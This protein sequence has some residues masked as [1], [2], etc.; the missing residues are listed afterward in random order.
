MRSSNDERLTNKE[1]ELRAKIA[2]LEEYKAVHEQEEQA[3]RESE[4]RIRF[5][6]DHSKELI[7]ILNKKG[8]IVF[9]NNTALKNYGYSEEEII[10]KSIAH[11]LTKTS[12]KNAFFALAQEFLRRPQRGFEV[13]IKAK[14]GEIR[15]LNIAEGSVPIY[16]NGKLTSVMIRAIDITEQK[17]AES[18]LRKSEMRFRELWENAP[19][20]YHALDLRGTITEA[21][22][23]EAVMLGYSKEELVGKSIFDFILPEQRADARRRFS[24]KISGRTLPRA[25]NRVYVKKDGSR[26][27]VAIDDILERDLEGNITG[28]RTAMVDI[29]KQKEAEEALRRSE[30]LYRDLVEN[31]GI[32]ILIDDREGNFKYFNNKFAKILGYSPDELKKLSVWSTIHPDDVERVTT[33]NRTRLQGRGAPSRYEFKG[34]R[35]DGSPI[36]LEKDVVV[37]KEGDS[38]IGTRSYIWDISDRK[39]ADEALQRLKTKLELVDQIQGRIPRNTDLETV[40]L[41]TAESIGESFGYYKISVNLYDSKTNEIVYLTGWNKTGLPLPRGHRQKLG[42]GLIG[43]AGLLRQTIVANDVSKEPGY[44]SLL[45]ATK[46]ELIIPLLIE[47]QLL[48][49]LDLQATEVN[50]FSKDDVSVLKAVANYVAYVIAEKQRAEALA[51]ERNL[52]RTLID[53]LPDYIYVKDAESRFMIANMA[54]ARSFGEKT[55]EEIVGKTDRD[56]HSP[57]LAERFRADEQAVLT[58]GQAIINREEFVIDSSGNKKWILSTKLPMRDR[59]GNIVGL[60]GVGRDITERKLAEEAI[61]DSEEKF[62]RLAEQSPNIVFIYV[63]DR[64]VYANARAA[65]IMGYT[66]EEICSPDFDFLDL[67][68]PESRDLIRTYVR[69]YQRSEDVP[70]YECR[71][72]TKDGRRIETIMA[73]KLIDYGKDKGLLGIITDVTP[74]KKAEEELKSTEER[75]KTIFEYAPDAY[76]LT[77]LKGT[78]IDGNK[79]AEKLVSGKKEEFIGK[80]IFKVN[81]LSLDQIP[82]AAAL[83]AKNVMGKPTGPDEFV[84]NSKDGRKVDVEIS[85]YPV[86]IEGKTLVLAIARDVSE[87]KRFENDLRQTTDRLRKSLGSIINVLAATVEMRDPYTAGHQKRVADLG[88]VIATEMALPQERIEAIR[89]AGTIHD[90]GKISV[91]AEI[92]SKPGRLTDFEFAIIKDHCRIS[93]EILKDIEFP[94][95]VAQIVHQHHERWNGSGYPQG[96]SGENVLLEARIIGV[97][98]VVEAMASHRPYRPAQGIDKALEEISLQKGILYDPA[99]VEACLKVIQA[100]GFKFKA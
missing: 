43:K 8:R 38:L 88:R 99:V 41:R 89:I 94:W 62:R 53:N 11:F 95:P 9:A 15:Y 61:R 80:S 44:L 82:K 37:L 93:F 45:S 26:I 78:I 56:F 91:P 2:A 19:V 4:R 65:E 39:R 54:L 33:Y 81:L 24:Q 46:A 74:I 14:S 6:L 57:E 31:S 76:Y 27:W 30:K 63:K 22:Q 92:L 55:P 51:N 13:Q 42:E 71:L 58:S 10:G 32:A 79:A 90:I 64:V 100:K 96:L 66:R 73:T 75:F 17:K 5:L 25:A 85:T 23:T 35:K 7:L 12:L 59:L 47:D 83:L 87:R 69:R 16:E 70:P 86:Q 49:V 20:A 60:V 67:I 98:D 68:A 29:T 28:I 50:A 52:I 3:L 21:N 48:G 1:E 97:A 36:D 72:L 18:D 34:I 77:D 40:L 84:L